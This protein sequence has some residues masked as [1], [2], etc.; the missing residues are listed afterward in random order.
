VPW[1]PARRLIPGWHSMSRCC[2]LWGKKLSSVCRADSGH[3]RPRQ[4]RWTAV[5]RWPP[6]GRRDD[7]WRLLAAVATGQPMPS[8]RHA[9]AAGDGGKPSAQR[10]GRSRSWQR[11][12]VS[13]L[14]IRP[15]TQ[16]DPFVT[17]WTAGGRIGRGY[18]CSPVLQAGQCFVSTPN[19]G[20]LLQAPLRSARIIHGQARSR[21]NAWE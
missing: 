3:N 2:D 9:C 15:D 12:T 20:T 4:G 17:S 14:T 6:D 8:I 16:A 13:R 10:R 18:R 5:C 21:H 1:R 19:D 7:Q 11:S